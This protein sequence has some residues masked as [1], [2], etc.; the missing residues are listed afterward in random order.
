MD[1]SKTTQIR[2]VTNLL[3]AFANTGG[4]ITVIVG[5]IGMI[6]TQISAIHY[7][8]TLI[9]AFYLVE[10][11]LQEVEKQKNKKITIYEAS[12]CNLSEIAVSKSSLMDHVISALTSLKRYKPPPILRIIFCRQ[13]K[14]LFKCG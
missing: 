8:T 2:R 3:D 10:P 11:D 9:K 1:E 6:M 4:I 7:F 13:Q 12:I 5:G 14:S